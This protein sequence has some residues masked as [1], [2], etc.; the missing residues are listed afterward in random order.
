[1]DPDSAADPVSAVALLG[2]PTR[3]RLYELVASHG[4]PVGRDDAA[5]AAGVSRELAAFHLD[6]LVA[7]GLLATEYRRRSGR[8]GPG[9]GRPAKLYRRVTD[10]LA[11]SFPPRRYDRAAS[12][13]ADALTSLDDAETVDAVAASARRHGARLGQAASRT[14]APIPPGQAPHPE[15]LLRLLGEAGY[16]PWLDQE[17]GAIRVRNCP[18]RVLSERQ[19]K[20]TCGMNAAWAAGLLEGLRERRFT[21]ELDPEPAGCCVVFRP[22]SPPSRRRRGGVSR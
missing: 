3:R 16:E 10:E 9:A 21:A 4:E 5:A 18:Y 2:D 22:N 12:V 14:G 13:F 11:I 7:G 15:M 20:L 17:S 1:M 8:S 6:R 19:R